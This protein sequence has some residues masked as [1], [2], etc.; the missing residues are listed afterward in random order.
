MIRLGY[1]TQNLTI[2][3]S[4]NRTLRLASLADAEKVRGIV[5]ENV[6]G[7]LEILR[8][9]AER[10]VMLFRI[11]Q[12]LI[13]FASHP[14]FPYDWGAEHGD[15]LREAGALALSLDI[16]L[17]VHPGQYIQ[18]SS[19]RSDVVERS[20]AELRSSAR[21]LSLLGGRD[22]VLVLHLG[23]A[24]EGKAAAAGRFV[25]A[26][27]P[28][29][30]VLR[31]MALENDE[32][33]WTVD[34]TVEV[35]TSLE[36]PAITDTLNNSLNPGGLTLEEALD[37]SLPTWEVRGARPKV[38]L[39]SQDPEKQSGAHAYSVE[40]ADWHALRAAL[41]HREAD[42]MVEAKGKERALA[43]LGVRIG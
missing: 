28:E 18:P 27:R 14:A 1:P 30:E 12:S 17:S 5:R 8:W 33:I 23:G 43:P 36:V 6:A 3:A 40:P 34:E 25:D 7:L 20:L 10:G 38:H 32:R 22:P 24:K 13:P 37:L 16:R 26:L 9:N 2:P 41:D 31:Y 29:E 11:G 21:L 4:T 42:V 39:S 15:E 19:L 35:A